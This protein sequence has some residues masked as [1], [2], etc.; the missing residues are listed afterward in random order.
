MKVNRD[1]SAVDQPWRRKFLGF[2]FTSLKNTTIRVHESSVLKLRSKILKLC[3]SARGMNLENFIHQK[4]NPLIRGW[5]NYFKTADTKNYKKELDAWIRRRLRIVLWRQ[6]SRARV[7]YREL[8]ERG[9]NPKT[10]FMM[11]NSSRGPCRM[12]HFSAFAQAYSPHY[13]KECG[14]VSL[15]TIT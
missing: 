11:A 1:K 9:V 13:F 14:L 6:W 12:S 7:K 2:S 3:R 10:C 5:G 15:T 4:L 8:A